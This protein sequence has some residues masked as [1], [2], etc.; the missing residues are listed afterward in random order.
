MD[1]LWSVILGWEDWA[2]SEGSNAAA[3]G[4]RGGYTEGLL[5][6]AG[7]QAIRNALRCEQSGQSPASGRNRARPVGGELSLCV[8]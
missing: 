6:S 2:E 1:H 3:I 8:A 5:A 7:G 4:M